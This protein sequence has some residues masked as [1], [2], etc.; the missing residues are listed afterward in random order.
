MEQK[1]SF[2]Y[3]GYLLN[4]LTIKNI[5]KWADN[6]LLLENRT[7][8]VDLLIEISLCDNEDKMISLLSTFIDDAHS[9]LNLNYYLSLYHFLGK[10][11]KL[12]YD[13]IAEEMLSA[14]KVCHN[15]FQDTGFTENDE[16]YGLFFSR[17]SDYMELKNENLA[18]N[19]SM[20]KELINF[21]SIYNYDIQ[22]FEY[23][24][25]SVRGIEIAGL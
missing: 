11:K 12:P 3:T 18:P 22:I 16:K 2:L 25:F 15:F 21:L 1:Y 4:Y 5:S 17:L 24:R 6:E 8:P 23:F 14:Y 9:D 10:E 19:I 20:P 7:V 13:I